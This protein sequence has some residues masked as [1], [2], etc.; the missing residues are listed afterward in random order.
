MN[1]MERKLAAGTEFETSYYRADGEGPGIVVIVTAGVHGNEPA[2]V[3]AARQ[4]VEDLRNDVLRLRKGRLIVV[5]LVNGPAFKRKTRG[6]PDLNRTFPRRPYAKARH[7]VTDALFRLASIHRVAWYLDLHEANGLSQLSRK[8]LGQTLIVN[9]GSQAIPV[10]R[11]AAAWA[12]GFILNGNRKFN[13]R[14]KGLPGSGRQAAHSLLQARAVT[15]E[16]CW[17]LPLRDR[18]RYQ[19]ALLRRMLKETGIVT[20]A[21]TIPY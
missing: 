11:Q 14:V 17:S 1:V 6:V 15:F 19:T 3:L 21:E 20:G 9:P 18:V 10:V 5:P 8:V 16:T 2:G 12:N 4:L 13:V 7:P